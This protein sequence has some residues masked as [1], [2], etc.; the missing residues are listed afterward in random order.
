MESMDC[1]HCGEPLRIE[2]REE[3]IAKPIGTWS[4]AG[5]QIKFSGQKVKWPWAVCDNCK[6]ESR[7]ELA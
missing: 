3:I 4:L 2:W 6:M 5:Q 7:G 1:K